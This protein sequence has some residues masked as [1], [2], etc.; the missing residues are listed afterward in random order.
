[1]ALH[2]KSCGIS[3]VWLLSGYTAH[4]TRY[5][6]GYSYADI[7]GLYQ[8]IAI[9]LCTVE[10]VMTPEDLRFLRKRLGYS[11]EELGNE[12]EYTAQAV[13]KWEKGT[14]GIPVVVSRLVRL[15]CLDRFA[16]NMLL[17]DAI[18]LRHSRATDRL[19]F[20]YINSKW[21]AAGTKLQIHDELDIFYEKFENGSQSSRAYVDDLIIRMSSEDRSSIFFNDRT[22]MSSNPTCLE[23]L[24]SD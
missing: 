5:G 11:Q 10:R 13:A 18:T 3:D 15:I 2:Y 22:S 21:I 14:S 23:T 16:P 17:H 1:M 24:G 9:A 7:D 12:F 4:E 19:E 8:A 6:S 20:E